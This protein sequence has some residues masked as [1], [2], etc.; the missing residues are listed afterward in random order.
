[1]LRTFKQ[2]EQRERKGAITAN[3]L[4][5][6]IIEG[7]GK[8]EEKF[9]NHYLHRVLNQANTVCEKVAS[10]LGL[11]GGFLRVLQFPTPV[12]TR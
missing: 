2:S 7:C 11:G 6:A 3:M 9:P 4:R 5:L 1:M 10:D 12:T 8:M